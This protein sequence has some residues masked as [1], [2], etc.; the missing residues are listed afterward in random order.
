MRAPP[1]HAPLRARAVTKLL[2]R[3]LVGMEACATA[4]YWA[5]ELRALGHEVRLMQAQYVKAYVSG[6]RTMRRMRRPFARRLCGRRCASC[7]P[8]RLNSKPLCCWTEAASDWF[9]SA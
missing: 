1:G 8:R 3:C 7:R 5:R 6:T 2:R 4:H 9:A